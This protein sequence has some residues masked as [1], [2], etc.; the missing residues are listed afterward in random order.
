[1]SKRRR[2]SAEF[3]C[4]AVEQAARS[5]DDCSPPIRW[6]PRRSRSSISCRWRPSEAHAV[7]LRWGQ[8]NGCDR[9]SAAADLRRI[10]KP[11]HGA[12]SAD[13][14]EQMHRSASGC[15][16]QPS[17]RRADA[18][19]MKSDISSREDN[20]PGG[21]AVASFWASTDARAIWA[22]VGALMSQSKASD[23]ALV[24]CLPSLTLNRSRAAASRNRA[25]CRTRARSS[26]SEIGTSRVTPCSGATR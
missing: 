19:S 20:A 4:G 9:R 12:A 15:T 18:L 13:E 24:K 26:D 7:S 5:G 11:C 1:M 8:A 3:M 23:S 6:A 2:Y 16:G 22:S 10:T 17:R 14:L 25:H 21:T